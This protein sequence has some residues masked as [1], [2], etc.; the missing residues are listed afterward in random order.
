MVLFVSCEPKEYISIGSSFSAGVISSEV[1]GYS[2]KEITLKIKF[3]ISGAG[4]Q[5]L[6]SE[7]D[8]EG[9]LDLSSFEVRGVLQD[10]TIVNNPVLVNYS[11]ALLVDN[12]FNLLS[13]NF[14]D[15]TS[16][17]EFFAR[18]YF[19]NA[20]EN[21]KF[22]FSI[23]EDKPSPVTIYGDGYTDNAD[24]YDLI[25]A[26]RLNDVKEPERK[27]DSIPLIESLDFMLDYINQK[28]PAGNRNLLL[29]SS[30]SVYHTN[31]AAKTRI[32]NKAKSLGIAVSTLLFLGD[33]T[34]FK[35]DLDNDDLYF[36]LANETGGFVFRSHD[37]LYGEDIL[38]L[39]PHLKNIMGGDN[40]YFEATWKIIP[41]DHYTDLFVPGF[42]EKVDLVVELQTG[43]DRKQFNMPFGILIK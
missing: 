17:T 31:S 11:C 34:N 15:K 26:N 27:M 21:N 24:S 14:N 4:E 22:L 40:R 29:L 8:I 3:F 7:S 18:N 42:F 2:D 32:V 43:D 19:K 28:A 6:I 1:T 10:L 38:I 35:W 30:W 36:R 16:S 9:N 20:G 13:Y 23:F 12:Y 5:P 25:L 41:D 39:A 33:I 37:M